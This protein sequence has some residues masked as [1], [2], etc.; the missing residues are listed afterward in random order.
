MVGSCIP[1]LIKS[2]GG[3]FIVVSLSKSLTTL[4]LGSSK[5]NTVDDF[6]AL[7]LL[8]LKL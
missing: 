5:I 8:P 1:K 3:D 6:M 4:S 2:L 7:V